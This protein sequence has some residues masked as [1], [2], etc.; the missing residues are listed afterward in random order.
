MGQ[1]PPDLDRLGDQ[2]AA[3]AA[4]SLAARRR[5]TALVAR[6]AATAVVAVLAFTA[7]APARLGPG[8]VTERGRALL[9]LASVT[10]SD[11]PV[12][13]ACDQP[14]GGRLL[15]AACRPAPAVTRGRARRY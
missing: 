8:A 14:R 6:L 1:L 13:I 5:R 11:P 10:V 12:P 9:A 15:L 7:F 3:A 2:L 4:R